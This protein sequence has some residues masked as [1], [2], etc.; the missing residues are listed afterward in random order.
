VGVW[1]APSVLGIIWGLTQGAALIFDDLV[2][3]SLRLLTPMAQRL[4]S[5]PLRILGWVSVMSFMAISSLLLRVTNA[6]AAAALLAGL[7]G[8]NGFALPLAIQNIVPLTYRK[9]IHFIDT[10]LIH[11]HSLG[12]ISV[13]IVI[14]IC[15]GVALFAHPVSVASMRIRRIYF[16]IAIYFVLAEV[17]QGSVAKPFFLGIHF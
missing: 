1:L 4:T 14:L 10:P 13:S 11:N 2:R 8:K 12:L 15:F 3:K 9:L 7:S 16:V 5:E 17:M 6:D